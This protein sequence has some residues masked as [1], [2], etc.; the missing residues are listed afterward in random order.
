MKSR[1]LLAA[2]VAMPLIYLAALALGATLFPGYR[3]LEDQPS[4]LGG[5]DAAQPIAF[6]VGLVLT[7]AIGVAGAIGIAAAL[8]TL[9]K[10]T[11]VTLMG[12]FTGLSL[13]LAS[14]GL[15]MGGVFPLPNPLHYGFG[16]ATFGAL[17]PLLGAMA[18]W[19]LG[20]SRKTA[21]TLG[22]LFL[23][24]LA[25]VLSQAPPPFAPGVIMML[26]VSVLCQ[27]LRRRQWMRGT[28]RVS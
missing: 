11:V 7:G 19:R 3:V 16:L 17:T 15:A 23:L 21:L 18:L 2:G 9:G 25:L 26:S 1:T 13:L 22:G 20:E 14:V 24:I 4:V 28:N 6:N 12:G 8:Q 10:N 27:A 5:P